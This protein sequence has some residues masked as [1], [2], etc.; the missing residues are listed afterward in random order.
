[1]TRYRILAVG[2]DPFLRKLIGRVLARAGHAVR[3][4]SWHQIST[5]AASPDHD[6]LLI[7]LMAADAQLDAIREVKES[8]QAAVVV[9]STRDAAPQR[10]RALDLGADDFMLLPLD[11]QD[12]VI[13]I[14]AALKRQL[15]SEGGVVSCSAGD[16]RI[17][18]LNRVV[19]KG[20]QQVHLSRKEFMMLSQLA[21]FPGRLITHE[22]MIT[23][24]WTQRK[25]NS[26]AYL[27]MLVKV[28]RG[29]LEDRPDAPRIIENEVGSGYRL[30]AVPA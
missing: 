20:G 13:R 29:K 15:I 14:R 24:L 12:L 18:L 2:D 16:V 5:E 19:T 10:S 21:R 6:V 26:I 7:D 22:Q 8:S 28:L 23:R 4:M 27:R 11:E 9:L 1:M 25:K 30:R 3:H 17:D